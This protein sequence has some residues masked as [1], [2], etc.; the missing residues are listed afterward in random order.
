MTDHLSSAAGDFPVTHWS[1]VLSTSAAE[2]RKA[3]EAME[4]LC[5]AYWYPLYA[6][7]RRLGYAP[8]DAQDLTQDF[9]VHLLETGLVAKADAREGRFR[10]W[11]LVSMKHFI[12]HARER[13]QAQKRGGCCVIVPWNTEEAEDRLA[14]ERATDATPESLY[15]RNWALIVLEQALNLLHTEF[16]QTGRTPLFDH[17]R[18][19]LEGDKDGGTYAEA[20]SRLGTTEGTIKV[21][22]N[23]MRQRYRELL[24]AVVA[25]TVSNPPEVEAEMRHLVTVLRG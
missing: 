3:A 14:R 17:L 7:T 4:K 2:P 22:V 13:I 1:V 8:A 10:S 24:R 6:F 9:F 19:F 11:L 5:R 23:R 20:A 25:H 21:T 12:A 18:G 15:E 16:A